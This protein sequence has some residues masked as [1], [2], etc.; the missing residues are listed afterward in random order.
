MDTSVPQE[1][2]TGGRFGANE[3]EPKVRA[4][5]QVEARSY[6]S[7]APPPRRRE[8]T[9]ADTSELSLRQPF[10]Y[11]DQGEYFPLRHGESHSIGRLD[12]E[13]EASF[14]EDDGRNS[15]QQYGSLPYR[16][17]GV[18]R[19]R[20][21]G[22]DDGHDVLTPQ[23][24]AAQEE[25]L[26]IGN[27]VHHHQLLPQ[28]PHGDRCRTR[29]RQKERIARGTGLGPCTPQARSQVGALLRPCLLSEPFGA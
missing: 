9:E 29:G 24:F 13:L 19:R 8:G 15:P 2:D 18:S 23:Q 27:G 1:E 11:E 3:A 20:S 6:G 5:N 22:R 7:P 17:D 25:D 28:Q 10:N 16:K 26:D 4:G 21:S 14:A 12:N